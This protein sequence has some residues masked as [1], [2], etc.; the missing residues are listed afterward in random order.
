MVGIILFHFT[1]VTSRGRL[2]ASLAKMTMDDEN[3]WWTMSPETYVKSAVTNVE[4]NQ[5]KS[6][7][8]L[9]GKCVTPFSC[10]DERI[11]G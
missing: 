4:E 9:P 10:G 7:K 5:T 3:Y 6:G 11:E 8:R 1:Q 2:K